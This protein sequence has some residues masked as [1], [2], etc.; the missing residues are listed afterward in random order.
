MT[1]E[2]MQTN[3]GEVTLPLEDM[4][5]AII[6][7]AIL[8]SFIVLCFK[9]FTIT[10]KAKK[11]DNAA[12]DIT[13]T[14]NSSEW[15][16]VIRII[17]CFLGI[18][19]SI[20]SVIYLFVAI[21][22]PDMRS[23]FVVLMSVFAILAAFLFRKTKKDRARFEKRSSAPQAKAP[24]NDFVYNHNVQAE[25]NKTAKTALIA[26]PLL[27]RENKKLKNLIA[28]M[29]ATFTPEMKESANLINLI[30]E[31]KQKLTDLQNSCA[32]E[33]SE[34]NRLSAKIA[35]LNK[36][37]VEVSEEMQLQDFGMYKPKYDFASSEKYK[38]RL[39]KI[40]NK[41]KEMI[42]AGTA[43]TGSTQWHVN[44]NRSEGRKMVKDMQKLLLRAFNCECDELINN[45]K[46]NTFDTAEKRMVSSYQAISKLGSI[47]AVEITTEY[48]NSKYKELCLAFEYRQKK[49]DE[50][51]EQKS[52]RAQMRE[53][54]KL[55]KEIE[56]ARKKVLKERAHYETAL[57]ALNKKI[58]YAAEG[59]LAILNDRKNDIEQLLIKI[60]Q[61]LKSIDYREAN[62]KAGYVY[63]ISN[64]GSFGENVYKI[65]MT[66]R[67]EPQDRIDELS[68]AS[69][70][71]NFDVHAMIFSDNAP[72]LEAA[73][74]RAFEDRKINMVNTRREFFRV[75]LD[76]IKAV[77]KANYDKTAEFVDVAEAEQYRISEKMYSH[78]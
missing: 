69:V 6:V 49:Q 27:K 62:I 41:Q 46:F 26:L 13:N 50:K 4:V 30:C 68:D 37:L 15:G 10:R 76:E 65:G 71:F 39:A 12:S 48:F 25:Q 43:V 18:I 8:V 9:M 23:E 24:D 64:V 61:T 34:Q 35:E 40:R 17:K 36:Q 31:Q 3:V 53:E 42:K 16:I 78:K 45:V 21:A 1:T 57:E 38:E 7:F 77:V 29:E 20:S 75:T 33:L 2:A 70:P 55:Q 47:M 54:I 73:L 51:E 72:A 19:C 63:V 28:E 5:P 32:Q 58:A 52:I 22:E 44:G 66:R 74:H 11:R 60:E 67:L 56:E 59:E 14:D